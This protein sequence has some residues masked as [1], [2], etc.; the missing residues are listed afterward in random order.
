VSRQKKEDQDRVHFLNDAVK[1]PKAICGQTL[2]A[3]VARLL[4]GNPDPIPI[5]IPLP[6][7][8]PHPSGKPI[9]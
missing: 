6:P 9:G 1:V 5:P 3:R 2:I 8:H 7:P 4:T